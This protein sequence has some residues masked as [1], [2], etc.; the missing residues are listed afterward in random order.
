MTEER[1]LHVSPVVALVA[2][3]S[4]LLVGAGGMYF[5]MRDDR[6]PRA[7]QTTAQGA[8]ATSAPSAP[9]VNRGSPT[10]PD[11][12][13]PLTTTAA[14]PA[15]TFRKRLRERFMHPPRSV[16][17]WIDSASDSMRAVVG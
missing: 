8:A 9:A 17:A 13:V 2:V 16:G 10:S 4:T 11:V 7:S 6:T 12:V 1:R 15:D 5:L 14:V 3:L